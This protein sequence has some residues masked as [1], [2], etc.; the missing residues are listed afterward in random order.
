M[1][2]ADDRDGIEY[3]FKLKVEFKSSEKGYKPV[4]EGQPS[5]TFLMMP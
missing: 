2:Q 4:S 3:T 5:V 1:V